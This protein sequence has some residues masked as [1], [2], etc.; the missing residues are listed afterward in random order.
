MKGKIKLLKKICVLAASA[1]MVLSA[2]GCANAGGNL[3]EQQ[4]SVLQTTGTDG[5]GRI[6]PTY[7]SVK[8]SKYVGVFY[9]LWLGEGM[10]GIY[11][12]SDILE[13][14]P[15][16][17]ADTVNNP[18][19]ASASSA[20][21]DPTVSPEEQYHY[22]EQPLYGY[23]RSTDKWVI[24]RHLE[25]LTFAGIDFLY[26]DFTNAEYNL[27]AGKP[28]N[29]YPEATYALMD[30]ILEMQEQG[31]EVPRIVP[32]VC[33]P[34]TS[35]DMSRTKTLEW[36]YNNYY[37]L[38]DFKY[39][40][41][42]FYADEERNPEQKPMIVTHTINKAFWPDA[43]NVFW[44]RM[45][46]WPILKTYPAYFPWMDFNVPQENY[47]GIMNVSVAQ[48]YS[49]SSEAYLALVRNDKNVKYRGRGASLTQTLACETADRDAIL[50]GQNVQYEWNNAINYQGDDEVW[51][52]TVTGWNEWIARKIMGI[53]G[54]DYATFVDTFSTAYSRDIEMMRDSGGYADNYY[55][56]LCANVAAFKYEN[57]GQSGTV[58]QKKQSLNYQNISDWNKVSREYLD[59]TGDA[60]NRNEKSVANVYTYTDDTARNDISSVKIANDK[61][62]L[63]VLVHTKDDITQRQSDD[64]GWMNLYVST[65]KSGGW[66]NY[67]FVINR[68]GTDTKASIERLSTVDGKI[69]TENSGVYADIFVS[70]KDISYRIPLSA[71]GETDE[72]QIKA[73]DNVFAG[74][75]TA[76]NDGVGV[77]S[78]GDIM[79]FYC[80]GDC[81]PIGRL[82][83]AYKL[84]K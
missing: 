21:Y 76:E 39:K 74:V 69:A 32:L 55:M 58:T 48:H 38:D 44:R 47:N 81:A 66:E 75:A 59:F 19:W 70:G 2:A 45:I 30:T 8:K 79:G 62:Y 7:S 46:A 50:R 68:D 23:Y 67:N 1:G 84:A 71:L 4:F 25:L 37:A 29:V 10:N 41:C 12:I 83:Y 63:Y 20:G 53:D 5:L 51:M 22:F 77:Y 56:Q 80:G 40:S 34:Y 11:D 6:K 16:L 3:T 60:A 78:F 73:C 65:G 43:L 26:L 18:L 42:W 64:T 72:I 31:F 17:E 15:G 36:V 33:N 14:H 57:G 24:R 27:N 54:R 28:Y 52:V 82:N 61:E 35:N 49:H 9:F 13:S